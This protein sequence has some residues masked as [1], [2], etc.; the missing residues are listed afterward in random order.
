M[1]SALRELRALVRLA[2]PLAAAQAGTT[3][4]GLVDVAV[5]GRL[6]AT[7][8]GAAGIGNSLFFAI[9]M[10]GMGIVMGVDPLVSQALGARNPL[11]ARRILWQGIWLANAVA[12]ALMIPM[13]LSPLLL[14]LI[15]VEP[16]LIEPATIY[17]HVRMLSLPAF[18]MFIALRSYLQA[19]GVTRAMIFAALI[20]NVFNFFAD[21]LLVFGG[22]I[23]P[24]WAGVL[25]RVPAM[26]VAGAALASVVASLVQVAILA[27]AIRAMPLAE[28][29]PKLRRLDR[30][31]FARGF[32][33]GLPVGLQ[34]GAEV[35]VFALAGLLAAKFG[36]AAVASHQIAL[37]LA[38]FTFTVAVG[39]GAAGSVRVGRAI[40][41]R[42][43]EGT[44]V[45]GLVAFGAGAGFMAAAAVLFWLFPEAL[46]SMMTNQPGILM[47]A[48]PLLAVAAVFQ[49]SDGLQA[50]G[51]GVLR[52]AG[53]TTYAFV[54]NIV[55]HWLVG[56][57]IAL[58]LGFS[59]GF[60]VVG[61][62]WGLCA[63]LTVVAVLLV[64]RFVRRSAG[65]IQPLESPAFPAP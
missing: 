39:V 64:V 26:G 9:A 43:R 46:A 58:W 60:G 30:E 29:V 21:V 49:I 4:M 33:V 16:S 36:E 38:S 45:A 18:L 10:L 48:V 32:R 44:R 52:G 15:G 7:E 2:L 40:G 17:V 50:V 24:E 8:L 63:G 27:W 28:P 19:H 31:L 51:A 3:L 12:F 5:L 34:M 62:W 25:R 35:G 61:I 57:P 37:T 11:H 42:D 53:D 6:G 20:A 47:A 1:P 13:G 56:L 59:L 22:G 14:P 55:G 54:A 23:L 41:A 65:E